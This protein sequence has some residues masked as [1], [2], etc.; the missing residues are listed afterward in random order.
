MAGLLRAAVRGVAL[1][2]GRAAIQTRPKPERV[3]AGCLDACNALQDDSMMI[4]DRQ[5]NAPAE[6]MRSMRARRQ[7]KGLREVRLVVPDARSAAIRRRIATQVARLDP[8]K[9]REALAWIESVS[10]FH[11]HEAR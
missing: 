10:E 5:M 1:S 2:H 7:A 6:R 8:D 4:K 3:F 9:E 11:S